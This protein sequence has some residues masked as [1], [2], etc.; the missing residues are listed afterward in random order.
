MCCIQTCD[1]T[2][3]GSSF[4][5]TDL[6]EATQPRSR[7]KQPTGCGPEHPICDG[8]V[9]RSCSGSS[10]ANTCL[11]NQ[12]SIHSHNTSHNDALEIATSGPRK[13]LNLPPKSPHTALICPQVPTDITTWQWAFENPS[14]SQVANPSLAKTSGAYIDALD[15]SSR[16]PFYEV[17]DLATN[18]SNTLVQSYG[19]TPGDTISLFAGNSIYY[20]VA[21][22]A[23]LRVGG[24][25]NGASPAYGIEEM[26]HAMKTANSKIIFTLPSCLEVA[27]QAAEIVGLGKDRI[28]LLEG[29]VEGTRD[30]E[31][32]IG[33]GKRLR[34]V[35][36]WKIPAGSSNKDVCGYVSLNRL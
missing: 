28:I 1:Y 9:T 13:Y 8:L 35:P 24:R 14:T 17:K 19:L 11:R 2:P 7:R 5:R 36:I 22:W 23:A 16:L 6:A 34:Q 18:L 15:P 10:I 12:T 29:S 25:V 32:L 33:E 30:L 31:D 20:P 26:V 27:T 4:V 3:H 21:I